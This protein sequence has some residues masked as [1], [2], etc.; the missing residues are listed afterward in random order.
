LIIEAVY[1][2]AGRGKL[3]IQQYP[4]QQKRVHEQTEANAPA[5][6]FAYA[7]ILQRSYHGGVYRGWGAVTFSGSVT[8]P[9]F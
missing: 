2:A 4:Q 8:M 6:L 1:Q 7:V 9:K 3:L 5:V